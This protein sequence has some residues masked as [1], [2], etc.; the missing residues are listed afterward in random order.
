MPSPSTDSAASSPSLAV[1]V[2]R[3]MA[4]ERPPAVWNELR[5]PVVIHDHVWVGARVTILKGVEIGEGAVVAAG[6]V[7]THDVPAHALV[8]GNPARVIRQDVDWN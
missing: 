6:S 5:S 1:V 2:N 4:P 8:G 3:A 7:V